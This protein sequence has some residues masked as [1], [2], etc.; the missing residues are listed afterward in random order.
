MSRSRARRRPHPTPIPSPASCTAVTGW[1][2]SADGITGR[3]TARMRANTMSTRR[4]TRRC[5]SGGGAT[6]CT[7]RKISSSGRTGT[8][9]IWP[10]WRLRCWRAIP[11][12]RFPPSA[13][14]SRGELGDFVGGDGELAIVVLFDGGDAHGFADETQ[15]RVGQ[16]HDVHR[17]QQ[18]VAPAELEFVAVADISPALKQELRGDRGAGRVGEFMRLYRRL[19]PEPVLIDEPL[20]ERGD[21]LR[22]VAARGIHVFERQPV[23]RL[24]RIAACQQY[25]VARGVG[26][27]GAIA[28]AQEITVVEAVL[29]GEVG[30]P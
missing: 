4:S 30:R 6:R 8:E 1:R 12:L 3:S 27:L 13:L 11:I 14:A 9:S 21:D 22:V 17:L 16:Q 25:R 18:G 2:G 5:S 23:C 28:P 19:A 15:G 10:L 26:S 29:P 7:G 20:V 24:R